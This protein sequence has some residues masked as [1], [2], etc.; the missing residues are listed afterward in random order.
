[1]Q[2]AFFVNLLARFRTYQYDYSQQQVGIKAKNTPNHHTSE[3]C[4]HYRHQYR[5]EQTVK[6]A[7]RSAGVTRCRHERYCTIDEKGYTRNVKP[8]TPRRRQIRRF[9]C[10]GEEHQCKIRHRTQ[11]YIEH[12]RQ[13]SAKN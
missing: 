13:Q 1:M 10:V 2:S 12:K 7:V 8:Q 4:A 9:Q 5:A 11:R 6:G 3:A